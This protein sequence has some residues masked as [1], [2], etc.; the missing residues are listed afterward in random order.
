MERT[1][2]SNGAGTQPTEAQLQE[3]ADE[4]FTAWR[5]L[6]RGAGVGSL[7]EVLYGSG[8]DALDPAQA[9]ALEL[10]IQRGAWRMSELATA[11]YVDASTATRTIDRLV[12]NGLAVR[13]PATDDG[14]GVVVSASSQGKK[15]CLRIQRGR[16]VLMRGFIEEFSF[17]ECQQLASLLARLVRSVNRM[18]E[19]HT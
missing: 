4:I 14:R 17:E 15:Q 6:R 7:K 2:E 3:V 19:D 18:A 9:D 16:Q 11:L 12:A 1:T 10:L 5:E 13:R 8:D